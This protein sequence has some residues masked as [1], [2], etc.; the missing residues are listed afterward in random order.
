MA[1]MT[2]GSAAVRRAVD[3]LVTTAG[4]TSPKR[5]SSDLVLLLSASV[6][7]PTAASSTAMSTSRR[8]Y[9]AHIEPARPADGNVSR[10]PLKPTQQIGEV[11]FPRH[12]TP[13]RNNR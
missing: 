7:A 12:R 13:E 2:Y 1:L 10:K 3:C 5:A 11:R 8:H 4:V 6:V 9:R